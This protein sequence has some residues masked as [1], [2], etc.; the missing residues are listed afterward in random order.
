MT[1]RIEEGTPIRIP[2]PPEDELRLSSEFIRAPALRAVQNLNIPIVYQVRSLWC[3]AACAEMILRFFNQDVD[4][5]EIASTML[6]RSCCNGFTSR[7]NQSWPVEDITDVVEEFGITAEF[8]DHTVRFSTIQD[9]IST[10]QTPLEAFI[11]WGEDAGGHVLLIDGWSQRNQVRYVKIKD[12]WDG[13]GEVRLTDLKDD[14]TADSG[15]WLS[16]WLRFREG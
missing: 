11:S 8:R 7:C 9:M 15:K 13:P 3:W 10:E 5:C 2:Q 12:P 4:K 1:L 6:E 14:Y 16:T